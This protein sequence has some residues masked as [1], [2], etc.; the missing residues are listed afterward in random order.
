M[1]TTSRAGRAESARKNV[2]P[3]P[4]IRDVLPTS[5]DCVVTSVD[6]PA[7]GTGHMPDEIETVEEWVSPGAVTDMR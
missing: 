3:K 4:T 6:N 1:P 5:P 7:H 2:S